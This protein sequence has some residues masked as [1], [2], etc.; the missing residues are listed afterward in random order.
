MRKDRREDKK[1][2][3]QKKLNDSVDFVECKRV[4]RGGKNIFGGGGD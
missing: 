4:W 3:K 2:R 1:E